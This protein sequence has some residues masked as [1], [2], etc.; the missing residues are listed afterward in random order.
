MALKT[1]STV[2]RLQRDRANFSSLP[3]PGRHVLE[4][5]DL[6]VVRIW[7]DRIRRGDAGG[8]ARGVGE[9]SASL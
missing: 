8:A 2:V 7:P 9:K 5:L 4:A 1:C 3:P 6:V